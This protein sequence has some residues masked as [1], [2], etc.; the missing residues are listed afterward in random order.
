MA[1]F[2]PNWS[3]IQLIEKPTN[4]LVLLRFRDFDASAIGILNLSSSDVPTANQA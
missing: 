2:I 3:L 4:T 1:C